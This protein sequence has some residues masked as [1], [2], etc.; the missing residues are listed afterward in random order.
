MH[1]KRSSVDTRSWDNL[2]KLQR[3]HQLFATPREHVQQTL[4]L[5]CTV[6]HI[7]DVT[8]ILQENSQDQSLV[9]VQNYQGYTPLML[10]I[11][12][13]NMDLVRL[14]LSQP[15]VNVNIKTHLEQKTALMLASAHGST[16][17]V[18][19]LLQSGAIVDE[20]DADGKTALMYA[21]QNQIFSTV[22]ALLK[23]KP[24][25]NKKDKQGRTALMYSLRGRPF[26]SLSKINMVTIQAL[27]NNG[28]ST[29]IRD[30]KGHDALYYCDEDER[31]AIEKIF[32]DV[33]DL[34]V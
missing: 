20:V 10:A 30:I 23:A 1:Q 34:I 17:I 2:V 28:A 25:P 16:G 6:G 15:N 8:T 14:I 19:A 31:D 21:A 18:Q 4:L 33:K 3:P 9:N 27:L 11:I 13:Q 29:E 26:N 5:A 22:Q 7:M 12:A 24:N 32:N